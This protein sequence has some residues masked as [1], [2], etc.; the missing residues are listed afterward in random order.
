MNLDGDGQA[1]KIESLHGFDIYRFIMGCLIIAVLILICSAVTEESCIAF[2]MCFCFVIP[3][4]SMV[5]GGLTAYA[6]A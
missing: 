6:Y 5:N 2:S 1:I 4:L 3:P